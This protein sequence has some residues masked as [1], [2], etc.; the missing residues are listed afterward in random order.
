[1]IQES[2]YST[3]LQYFGQTP[4]PSQVALFSALEKFMYT[5]DSKELF[6]IKGYAGTGKTSVLSAFVQSLH[7]FNI[8][9]V[10][11]APTGRAAKVFSHKAKKEALTIHKHI[12]QRKSKVDLAAGMSLRKNMFKHTVFLIDE[13]SMIGDYTLTSSGEVHP[14]NLLEDVIEYVFSGQNCRLIMMGDEGQLPPVGSD[15]SPALS[16][17]HLCNHFPLININEYRLTEVLRQA[18]DSEVLRN[19]TLLRNT[20]WTKYPTFDLKSGGDL[21][22]ISGLELQDYLESSYARVGG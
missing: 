21:H 5:Q 20:Q 13:A 19:A 7:A 16:K 1:M 2:F 10:L 6:L 18:E 3:F 4:T 22:R 8:Q 17:E 15:F 11:L 12:Y 9:T 14:R